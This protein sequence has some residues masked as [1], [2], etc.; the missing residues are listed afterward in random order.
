M[1]GSPILRLAAR[2]QNSLSLEASV[3]PPGG[4]TLDT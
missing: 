3:A 2:V 1:M 4:S